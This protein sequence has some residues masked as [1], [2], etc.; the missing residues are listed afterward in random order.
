MN[1]AGERQWLVIVVLTATV[2]VGWVLGFSAKAANAADV[3]S[4][5]VQAEQRTWTLP[6]FS[7]INIAGSPNVRIVPGER[8]VVTATGEEAALQKLA[9]FVDSGTLHI[10]PEKLGWFN[11]AKTLDVV[12][13]YREI[14][15]L[16]LAGS[17]SLFAHSATELMDG[18]LKIG[19]A[20]SGDIRLPEL[21]GQEL[22]VEVNGSG[23]VRVNG[24]FDR[25]SVVVTGSGSYRAND[26]VTTAAD[27]MVTGSGDAHVLA[28]DSLSAR[29]MGSGQIRYAG[30]AKV[31]ESVTG[32][33]RI[34]AQ[35]R[36]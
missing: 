3:D 24:R 11:G 22:D 17:A 33:G 15:S 35:R 12:I 34:V 28:S 2:V 23:N 6:E 5:S 4:G 21:R 32:S 25:Q 20:G 13:E 30:S 29:V 18:K 10:K 19:L 36:K 27:V 16:M 1:T 8:L 31:S 9:V 7:S 14:E 26:L